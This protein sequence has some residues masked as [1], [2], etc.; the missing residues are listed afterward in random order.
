MRISQR[1]EYRLKNVA[2]ASRTNLGGDAASPSPLRGGRRQAAGWGR[3]GSARRSVRHKRPPLALRAI[4][5]SRGEKTQAQFL[6]RH[7]RFSPSGHCQRLGSGAPG[8]A[9][10][11]FSTWRDFRAPLVSHS[12][13][14]IVGFSSAAR[15]VPNLSRSWPV[16]TPAPCTFHGQDAA[17]SPHGFGQWHLRRARSTPACVGP[18]GP[19]LP[20]QGG[21]SPPL[22]LDP[23]SRPGPAGAMG[24]LWRS[25]LRVGK[26]WA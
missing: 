12:K 17:A 15:T 18:S 2:G 11:M 9:F 10:L 13:S 21:R 3:C 22:P 4:S 23:G 8:R 26:D 16:T 24:G 1:R 20:H 19:W 6:Y 5:P 14:Q 7:A 25:G